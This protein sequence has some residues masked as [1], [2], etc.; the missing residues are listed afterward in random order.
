MMRI[1]SLL[2]SATEVICGLGLDDCLVGV[3][4][5]CDWP[6]AVRALPKVTHTHIPTDADSATIDQLVS[7]QRG[8]R[9]ALYSLNEEQMHRLR[10]DLIVSQTLCDVCAVDD[11]EVRAFLAAIAAR[12]DGAPQAMPRVIYLEPTRLR[13]VFENI[14]EVGSAAGRAAQAKEYVAGLAGRVEHVRTRAA[15]AVVAQRRRVR[16]VVLE[17]LTPLFTCGHW[18]PELVELAG[19]VEL[20]GQAGQR[21]RR[22]TA[23]ELILADPDVLVIACCGFSIERTLHDVPAFL[24]NPSFA[25]LRA[26]THRRVY[27]VDGSAYFSRPGPRLV[28]SLELLAGALWPGLIE[29]PPPAPEALRVL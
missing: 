21:S 4:H 5:E 14:V 26:V 3:T 28:D 6:P 13:D 29:S 15:A 18:T 10:P 19:G 7:A 27:V 1:V 23:E 9:R 22:A 2:P 20:L 8:R 17:W 24:A 16:T 11:A 25:R 12:P